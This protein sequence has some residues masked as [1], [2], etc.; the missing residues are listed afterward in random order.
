MNLPNKLTM[1]RIFLTLVIIAILTLPFE[2]AGIEMTKLFV[3]EAIVVDIK[4]II[5]G[6]L[7]I[8]ASLT[9]FVDGYI[10]RK[11]NLV[12]DF[13]KMIDAI[14]DKILV[15]SVLIIL[16]ATGFIHPII[17]VIIIMRDTVVNSIKMVAGNH[18]NVVAASWMGK[19]KTVCMM[20]GVS[21]TLFYNLPFELWNLRISDFLLIIATVLSIISAVQYYNANKKYIFAETK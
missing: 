10:A 20:T 5:A 16:S 11:Y 19:V 13:G 6:V 15:N 21:L 8:V 2:A 3:S 18:G 7:F 4:Y 12:T 1:I 14:A 17:P 9:D